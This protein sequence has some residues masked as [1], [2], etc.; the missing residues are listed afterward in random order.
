M[1]WPQNAFPD[2][3]A[4]IVIGFLG[5]NP[6]FEIMNVTELK[7]IR[8]RR[9]LATAYKSP[10]EIVN[11][12]MLFIDHSKA[13]DLQQIFKRTKGKG[14]LILSDIN[15]FVHKGRIIRPV[16]LPENDPAR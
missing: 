9:V 14:I 3:K 7:P 2:A 16:L 11:C 8:G 4:P 5:N 13:D 12:Q 10:K 1:E 6:M 15:G